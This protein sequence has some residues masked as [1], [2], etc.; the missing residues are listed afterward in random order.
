MNFLNE[1]FNFYNDLL[2]KVENYLEDL[3]SLDISYQYSEYE[4]KRFEFDNDYWKHFN[5]IK[6]SLYLI[7]DILNYEL[8][9]IEEEL[10][11]NE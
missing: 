4:L 1:K 2:L 8:F 10:K 11:K 5:D 6:C 3:E 7:I 9:Q